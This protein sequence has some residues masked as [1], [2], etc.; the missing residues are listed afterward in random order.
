M[1]LRPI[2]PSDTTRF[3]LLNWF[4]FNFDSLA[5][6]FSRRSDT[7]STSN[8]SYAD[9]STISVLY[10][11]WFMPADSSAGSTA[12]SWTNRPQI[13]HDKWLRWGVGVTSCWTVLN[14]FRSRLTDHSGKSFIVFIQ[15]ETKAQF[16]MNN[17]SLK[18]EV[19]IIII[20][21]TWKLSFN[22]HSSLIL[23]SFSF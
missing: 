22:Y 2:V 16:Y 5:N 11:P 19:I 7:W 18:H 6:D 21:L 1:A 12:R 8:V 23:R 4:L 20:V 9:Q 17:F 10:A 14:I 13:V 15:L 3:F